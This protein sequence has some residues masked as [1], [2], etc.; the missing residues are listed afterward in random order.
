MD[1]NSNYSLEQGFLIASARKKKKM[2]QNQLAEL[3]G[4]K[5]GA[6][7]KYEKGLRAIPEEKAKIISNVLNIEFT[8]KESEEQLSDFLVTLKRYQAENNY[9][10]EELAKKIGVDSS[11][12]SRIVS[13][14]RKPS[15]K[16]IEK[17]NDFLS[18]STKNIEFKV[19]KAEGEYAFPKVNRTEMGLRIKTIRKNRDESLEKFG[20]QFTRPAGKNVVSRWEKGI[21][22]PDIERLMNVAQLG[23]TTATYILYGS[24]FENML[25][26][27]KKKVK[28]QKLGPVY[29]GRRLRKIRKERKL[30]RTEFGQYFVPPIT[31]WSMDRYENGTDIPNTER[32]IQYAFIGKVSLEFLIFG[33]T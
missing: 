3:T 14:S 19:S 25:Q 15:K 12:L 9:T 2:S 11:L 24:Q 5:R 17:F 21:N 29:L 28:F 18:E 22:I 32:L 30:E 10:A 23:E 20:K 7:A 27:S 26:S 13:G 4:I 1:K 8:K 6:L 16:F 31:K 33:E